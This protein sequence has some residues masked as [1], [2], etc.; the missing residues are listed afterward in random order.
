MKKPIMIKYNKKEYVAGEQIRCDVCTKLIFDSR[1]DE[2]SNPYYQ[3][4]ICFARE[5]REA[6]WFDLCSAKCARK[7]FEVFLS[8]SKEVADT[9]RILTSFKMK[10]TVYQPPYD[11][12]T[13]IPEEV[14]IDQYKLLQREAD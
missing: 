14:P 2:K 4:N 13:I 3:S 7:Q 8:S 10:M 5:I 11:Y 1:H 6:I 12:N 9:A